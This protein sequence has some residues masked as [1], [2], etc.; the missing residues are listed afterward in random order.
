MSDVIVRRFDRG[1]GEVRVM[2]TVWRGRPRADLRLWIP[3]V[4]PDEEPD[5]KLRPTPKGVQLFPEELPALLEAVEALI[6]AHEER[7]A[8]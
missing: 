3:D 2:L 6:E 7:R 5:G 8:A 1:Y 4:G